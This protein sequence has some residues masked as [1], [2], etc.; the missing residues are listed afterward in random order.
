MKTLT[1][2]NRYIL[3]ILPRKGL[4]FDPTKWH[5]W[6]IKFRFTDG[7]QLWIIA[8]E[9]INTASSAQIFARYEY[10]LTST[11]DTAIALFTCY[12]KAISSELNTSQINESCEL[13]YC[14]GPPLSAATAVF[15][16]HL[17]VKQEMSYLS[18]YSITTL[19]APWPRN[20]GSIRDIGKDIFSSPTYPDRL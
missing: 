18:L 11:T 6:N 17:A 4:V 9:T 5:L 3:Q 1:Y 20:R 12:H 10:K 2:H 16:Q 14:E 19:E 7:L 15:L 13:R 8:S